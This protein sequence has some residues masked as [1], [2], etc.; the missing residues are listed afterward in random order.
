MKAKSCR[1]DRLA[2]T[3]N[4]FCLMIPKIIHYC[5]FGGSSLPKSAEKCI[6]SWKKHFP[7]Y[8]IKRWDETNYDVNII[9]YTRDAY[10]AKKYAFVS[11]Y[12]RLDI[13]NREGGIYFDTDVE[14]IRSFKD[15]LK[16]GQFMG[17]ETVAP[18]MPVM[19]APG[20]GMAME[21]GNRV[22][23]N[24]LDYY[25]HLAYESPDGQRF[26]ETIV[27][28]TTKI[29]KKLGLSNNDKI[30][31]EV[32]GISIYPPEYFCPLSTID[33]KLRITENTRSI[34]LYKQTW[35]SPFRKYGRKLIL[36]LGGPRL[37]A[38]LKRVVYRSKN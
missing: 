30:I 14:V 8:T 19:V 27:I 21:G 9:H 26:P 11:D 32:D 20:L 5:W 28:H 24:M 33:G 37:T 31:Q 25:K 34:H 10:A 7:D 23:G 12:A 15:I 6:A 3:Q 18:G 2:L 16:K 17:F 4:K 29:L 36:F 38:C 13:L 22:I 1:N 35:Q